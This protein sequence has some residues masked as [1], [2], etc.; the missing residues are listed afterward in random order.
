MRILCVHLPIILKNSRHTVAIA[1]G[2]NKVA[3]IMGALR[4]GIIDTLITDEYTARKIL[5]KLSD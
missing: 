4:T 3:A 1:C 2:D 5:E